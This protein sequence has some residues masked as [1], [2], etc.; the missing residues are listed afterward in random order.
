MT[1]ICCRRVRW[2]AIKKR[3]GWVTHLVPCKIQLGP[4]CYHA[5]RWSQKEGR[6]K[7]YSNK[8]KLNK[9]V[10]QG[11]LRQESHSRLCARYTTSSKQCL[12]KVY[13][14]KGTRKCWRWNQGV[15][16]MVD[17]DLSLCKCF[18]FKI[19]RCNFWKQKPS[20]SWVGKRLICGS[21][22][23]LCVHVQT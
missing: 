7:T 19:V 1:L 11:Q 23:H 14:F 4:G 17:A 9:E 5:T 2:R 6:N 10:T 8:N 3:L 18:L 12:P 21:C 16:W 15:P 20:E 22:A 13:C